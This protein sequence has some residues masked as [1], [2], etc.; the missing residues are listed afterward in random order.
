MAGRAVSEVSA[1]TIKDDQDLGKQLSL[2][3]LGPM[4]LAEIGRDEIE[5]YRN[6]RSRMVGAVRINKEVYLLSRILKEACL[7]DQFK[8]DIKPLQSQQRKRQLVL[9][10]EATKPTP[11]DDRGLRNVYK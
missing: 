10:P 1:R 2:S 5:L 11:H 7:W 4:Q 8:S 6:T 3:M 9:P